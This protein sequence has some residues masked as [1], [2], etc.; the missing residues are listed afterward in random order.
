MANLPDQ[1][2]SRPLPRVPST[3]PSIQHPE[4]QIFNPLRAAL[5]HN[6]H[7]SPGGGPHAPGPPRGRDVP[8]FL[9]HGGFSVVVASGATHRLAAHRGHQFARQAIRL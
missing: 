1:H 7:V 3:R 6:S 5:P 2:G 8:M 9:V 4:Q